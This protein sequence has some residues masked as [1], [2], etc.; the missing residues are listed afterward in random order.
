MKAVYD[1]GRSPVTYDFVH[2]LRAVEAERIAKGESDVRVSFVIGDRDLTERDQHFTQ[3]RKAWRLHN[4][5]VPLCRL[6]PSVSGYEVVSHGE[7]TIS[8]KLADKARPASVLKSSRAAQSVMAEWCRTDKPIVTITIRQSDL[9]V[10]RNSNTAEWLKVADWLLTV[11]YLPVFVPDTEAWMRGQAM[12]IGD[13]K[14]C[15]PA[16]MNVDLRL[17]LYERATLNCFTSGGPFGL[18]LYADL[19][20]LLCKTIFPEIHSCTKEVQERLGYAPADWPG[21]YQ[22][23][24]WCED[25]LEDVGVVLTE[26][27]PACRSRYREIP[28]LHVFAAQMAQRVKN[29]QAAFLRNLPQ[30]EQL[31]AN[32]RTAAV[33]CFGP[34]LRDS[35]RL[36][37]IGN[38]DVFT[39]SGAHDFL[40]DRGIIPTGHIECDPREHKADFTRRP[41]HRVNYLIAST[42]HPS[43]FDNLIGHSVEMWHPWD[44]DEVES[45]VM[46]LWPNAFTLLGGTNVGLRAIAVLSARGYRK[47]SIYGMDCSLVEG[48]RHAGPHSG[49]AQPAFKVKTASGR[50]FWTTRQLVSG[51]REMVSL[52]SLLSRSGMTFSIHGDSLLREMLRLAS[53]PDPLPTGDSNGDEGRTPAVCAV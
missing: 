53:Q 48:E 52:A 1:L 13:H 47:F 3:D 17:A 20:F 45:E 36:L 11:G 35:W 14:M 6:L 28:E 26:M 41:D 23:I 19:P 12:E 18:C 42:C 22:R 15:A 4:L 24:V 46:R 30:M 16:A 43:V 29:V 38:E 50:E 10:A 9:Q 25:T 8:Y 2:W 27:L 5:L 7:Q 33:V 51:A 31:P 40:I 32:E 21:P 34:T 39:V 49:K 44:G 37:T